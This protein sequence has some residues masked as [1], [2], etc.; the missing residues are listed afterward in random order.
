[1]IIRRQSK[2]SYDLWLYF[3]DNNGIY[4]KFSTLECYYLVFCS[5]EY[6]Y[7]TTCNNFL[8]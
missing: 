5:W 4:V 2:V 1:M 8:V 7:Y 3:L 6:S